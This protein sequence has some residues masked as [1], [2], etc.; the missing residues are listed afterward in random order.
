VELRRSLAPAFA[1][2]SA[3]SPFASF[4]RH[5]G[6]SGAKASENRRFCAFSLP[7]SI[8]SPLPAFCPQ[9]TVSL[10]MHILAFFREKKQIFRQIYFF[11]WP[12]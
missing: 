12:M 11:I 9:K 7:F 1:K 8:P 4:P 2:A 5:G 6:G 10:F 3:R